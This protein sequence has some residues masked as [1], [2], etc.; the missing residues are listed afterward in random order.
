VRAHENACVCARGVAPATLSVCA[1]ARISLSGH[2][3]VTGHLSGHNSDHGDG[4]GE[5]HGMRHDRSH[6]EGRADVAAIHVGGWGQYLFA[7]RFDGEGL[8][9]AHLRG[10]GEGRRT[11]GSR[12]QCP[13]SGSLAVT[14]GSEECT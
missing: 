6:G 8:S 4:H 1:C 7:D 9:D 12:K 5:D 14:Q 10:S 11:G 2:K 3:A 13:I